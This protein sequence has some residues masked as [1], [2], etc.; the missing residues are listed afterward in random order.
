MSLLDE[1]ASDLDEI[2]ADT[3]RLV[4]YAGGMFPALVSE[5]SIE[6]ELDTGGFVR[7]AGLVVKIRRGTLGVSLPKTG[8]TVKVDSDSYRIE[9]VTH[10][11]GHPLV[12][13]D[14]GPIHR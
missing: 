4:G 2:F 1:I 6:D 8:E 5:L 10:R 9:K 13:L 11:E 14:L 12:T 3:G 7:S